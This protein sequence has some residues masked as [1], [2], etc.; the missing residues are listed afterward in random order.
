MV[1]T[2]VDILQRCLQVFCHA[3]TPKGGSERR[4]RIEAEAEPFLDFSQ[5]ALGNIAGENL[6]AY[7]PQT[8]TTAAPYFAALP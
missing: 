7:R 8:P 6:R 4:Q 3:L 1:K 5:R 2:G